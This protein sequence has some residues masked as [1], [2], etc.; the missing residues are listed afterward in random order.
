[1]AESRP[2][3]LPITPRGSLDDSGPPVELTE[4]DTP[5]TPDQVFHAAAIARL[6]RGLAADKELSVGAANIAEVLSHLRVVTVTATHVFIEGSEYDVQLTNDRGYG[7]M[8][9]AAG[10]AFG[11]DRQVHLVV[12]EA[13]RVEFESEREDENSQLSHTL[14]LSSSISSSSSSSSSS[15]ALCAGAADPDGIRTLHEDPAEFALHIT[16]YLGFVGA[17]TFVR[18]FGVPDVQEALNEMLTA[19]DWDKITNYGGFLRWLTTERRKP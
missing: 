7:I 2:I 17:S 11:Q 18:R 19:H 9:W 14:S 16:H 15:S 8:L 12:S 10:D 13:Q 3:P 5:T 1:M 6:R 4:P